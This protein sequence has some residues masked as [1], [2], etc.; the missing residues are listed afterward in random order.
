[1]DE[2]TLQLVVLGPVRKQAE[3]ARRSKPVSS[4]LPWPLHQLLPPGAC[5]AS[6]PVLT[7]LVMNCDMELEVK[8][9]LSSS[10]P[11]GLDDFS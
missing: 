5:P 9:A 1:V 2:T 8:Q 3:Q 7:V 4:I 6:V 11:F 10:S